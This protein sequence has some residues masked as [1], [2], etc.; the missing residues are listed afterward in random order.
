MTVVK[1]SFFDAYKVKNVTKRKIYVQK[2]ENFISGY[3][4]LRC[5]FSVT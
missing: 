1:G 2:H 4:H 5:E 3:L